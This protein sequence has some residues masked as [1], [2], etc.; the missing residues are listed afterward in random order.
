VFAVFVASTAFCK[1]PNILLIMADDVGI[2]GIGCYGG[3]SYK[4]PNLD[5]MAAEGIRFT[6]AYSTPLCTPTRLQIMTGKYNHRNWLYFGILPPSEKTFGHMMK[7]F[8]YKTCIAGKWQLTSYDPPDFPGAELRRGTGTLPGDAGFDEYSLFHVHETEDKG[9]RYGD[10]TYDRNGVLHKVVKGKY[11]E[12]ISVDFILEFMRRNKN[13]DEPMFIYYPM[14]LPHGPHNPTPISDSWMTDPGRRLDADDKYFADMVEY[15]DVL[16]GRLLTGIDA[17][18]LSEDT[19][20]LFYS[21]NGTNKVID[22][23]MNGE[24]VK[25]GKGS[26]KQT[27]IRVPMIGHWPGRI[28]AGTVNSSLV[29]ASDFLPTLAG[30]AG[31]EV[32]ADWGEDGISFAPQL[33]D[34]ASGER[35]WVFCWYDPRPG[36]DKDQF[37]REIFALDKE[38]KYFADGRF[39][40]L[41]ELGMGE[42]LLDVGQLTKK[43]ESARQRLEKV[44]HQAMRNHPD[45]W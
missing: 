19:L 22:S 12:D 16:V 45:R 13:A 33:L 28:A 41:E 17:L 18:G 9:S 24:I 15:M 14:A 2:E 3:D 32:P 21:D 37:T 36:W 8:G 23:V 42:T 10:P 11:G 6:H 30:I 34:G 43:E 35:E 1:V 25:G 39:Y 40:A 31:E 4:T 26:T 29:D 38:Y 5:K 20:V 7:S 44:I 27:G